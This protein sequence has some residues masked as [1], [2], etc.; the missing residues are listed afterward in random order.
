MSWKNTKVEETR[1]NFIQA[2]KSQQ[3]YFIEV[4]NAFGISRK[5]GYKWLHRYNKEGK[6]GLKDRSRKPHHQPRETSPEV[7]AV[8]INKRLKHPRWGSK[9]ILKILQREM[10]DRNWPSETTIFNILK[11]N[12]YV[13]KPYRK[14]RLALT[15]PFE[16]CNACN[17]VWSADF[18]GWWKTLDGSQCQPFTLLDTHSRFL[19]NCQ[20]A[21]ST[22][23]ANVKPILTEIFQE[24]GMPKRF[25][26]DNGPPFATH[27]AGRLSRLSIW[28]IKLGITP[29]WITPGNP[30]ENG[31]H[32]RMH[33][34]LKQEVCQSP[35]EDINKQNEQLARFQYEY[36]FVRPHEALSLETPNS[37]YTPSTRKWTG[38]MSSPSYTNEYEVRKIDKNGSVYWRGIKFFIS[39]I[40][41]GETVGIKENGYLHEVYFGSI[42]L[43]RIDPI[44]GYKKV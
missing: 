36:N 25:R 34:T 31:K 37:I 22:S 14:K 42:L 11:R 28:L 40:L 12:G 39:E 1:F 9:K 43:G 24:F 35:E 23:F 41:Y 17:D 29:E 4:C 5:T 33:R 8:I 3:G 32:E 16:E 18:K 6:E 44:L 20:H 2:V 38:E 26:S 19:L 30:Q 21:K 15:A 27:G 10:P 13:N 7:K